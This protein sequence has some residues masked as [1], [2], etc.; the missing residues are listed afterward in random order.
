LIIL[1]E[2]GFVQPLYQAI[3]G[4]LYTHAIC[5]SSSFLVLSLL[6][7]ELIG[8]QVEQELKAVRKKLNTAVTESPQN[9]GLNHLINKLK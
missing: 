7:N 6:E 2:I 1:D 3:Q 5:N 4:E 8:T 9:I